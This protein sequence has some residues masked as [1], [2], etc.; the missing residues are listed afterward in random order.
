MALPL[1]SVIIPTFNRQRIIGAAVRSALD[2]TYPRL[3]VIVVDDGST[4]DTA[5]VLHSFGDA[6]RVIRQ[7][8]AGPSAARNRGVACARG[9]IIAFLDSDDAWLPTKIARQVGVMESL[10]A[11][12]PCCL[13]NIRF[14]H[15]RYGCETSFAMAGLFPH[16]DEG[17]WE[18]PA[19]ILAT[20]VILFNQAVAVRKE[21]LEKAGP[22]DPGLKLLEDYDLALRL[23]VLGPWGFIQT[24]LIEYGVCEGNSLTRWGEEDPGRLP[25][26]CKGVLSRFCEVQSVKNE[27]LVHLA[28][29]QLRTCR[30][31]I[32]AADLAK[33]PSLFSCLAG[34][35]VAFYN[36]VYEGLYRRSPWWPQMR[37][38]ALDPERKRVSAASAFPPAAGLA[39][40]VDRRD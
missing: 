15:R 31:L 1:V 16:L 36:R 29:R 21:A 27:H 26:V 8:N 39:S 12:T 37:V 22:F 32:L 4:D 23:S 3:E 35:G 33:A 19:E 9:E 38:A 13:G 25:R 30:R 17:L 24:P 20:R 14:P 18:N 5:G 7:E 40:V 34:R 28:N 2:Q 10:G 6:I 11:K